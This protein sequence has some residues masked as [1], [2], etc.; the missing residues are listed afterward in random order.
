MGIDPRICNKSSMLRCGRKRNSSD[1]QRCDD[2]RS[3]DRVI[4]PDKGGMCS[5]EAGDID[6]RICNKSSTLRCGRKRYNGTRLSCDDIQSPDR[7][8]VTDKGGMFTRGEFSSSV[9]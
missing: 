9:R 2:I 5:R 7:V 8:I 1:I 6:P 4:V 3:T